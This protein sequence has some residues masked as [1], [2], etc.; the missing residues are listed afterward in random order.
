MIDRQLRIRTFSSLFLD[1]RT[2]GFTSAR[3]G[4]CLWKAS[5]KAGLRGG[6]GDHKEVRRPRP[7]HGSGIQ[8]ERLLIS[9][10]G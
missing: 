10:M 3:A 1:A 2:S 8:E 9:G 5:K 4:Q 6:K 7:V